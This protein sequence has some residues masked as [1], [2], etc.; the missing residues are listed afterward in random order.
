MSLA[1]RL[2]PR[3]NHDTLDHDTLDHDTLE[4]ATLAG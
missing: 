4:R 1:T 3:V 2:S